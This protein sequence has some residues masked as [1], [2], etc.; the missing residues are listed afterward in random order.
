MTLPSNTAVLHNGKAQD[1]LPAYGAGVDLIVTSPPYD[2]LRRYAGAGMAAWDFYAVAGACVEALTP[3]GIICWVVADGIVGGGESG[4]RFRQA[5][6]FMDAGLRL[7]QTLHYERA[8]PRIV[9]ANRCHYSATDIYVLSNG[10]PRVANII[11]DRRNLTAGSH[12]ASRYAA[13]RIGDAR[14]TN[15]GRSGDVAEYG[16]RTDIWRYP[17]GSNHM[18]APGDDQKLPHEHPAAFPHHLAADLI[19]T[20]SNAGDVVCDPMA[21]SGTTLRAAVLLGRQAIG[22]EIVPDYCA[23]IQQR[24][25]QQVLLAPAA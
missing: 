7:H 2:G 21:G 19:R 16:A 18:A 20:Y 9:S 6:W 23:L 10:K 15:S 12:I 25:A 11:K 17:G 13:G 24:M 5:L 3:G 8:M 14:P 22:I 4:S 1:I